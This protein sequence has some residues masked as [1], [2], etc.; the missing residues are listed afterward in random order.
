MSFKDFF[1]KIFSTEDDVNDAELNAARAKH[2]IVVNPLKDKEEAEV[3]ERES[4]DPWE[5]VGN[6]RMNF[7][8]GSWASKK[9]HIVGEEKVKKELEALEAKRQKQGKGSMEA[10]L[11]ALDKKEKESKE[12]K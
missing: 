1:K 5:E 12:G 7:F 11:E 10:E 3:E 8:V 2:G 9:F 6:A 4:Y